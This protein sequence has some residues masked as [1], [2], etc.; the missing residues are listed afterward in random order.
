MTLAFPN[1]SRSFD[2]GRSA[3]RFTGYDGMFQIPFLI[4]CRALIK[5]GKSAMSETECL[6]A[7]DA[8]VESVHAAARKA[9]SP[10]RH[11]LYFLGSADL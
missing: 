11:T 9:Y 6:A 3:I 5:S 2:D 8:A 1:L 10:G 7:F 4:D